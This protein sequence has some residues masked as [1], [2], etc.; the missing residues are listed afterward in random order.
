MQK[1]ISE[2]DLSP[3]KTATVYTWDRFIC[4]S[5]IS[6]SLHMQK[7]FGLFL[8]DGWIMQVRF[9]D[10][11]LNRF[12]QPDTMGTSLTSP[13]TWNR[14]SYVGNNSI[15]AT[16]PSG[17]WRVED[18]GGM[19]NGV[20]CASYPQL[21]SK[22]G[23]VKSRDELAKMRSPQNPIVNNNNK[24]DQSPI[25]NSGLVNLLHLFANMTQDIATLIDLG[26]AAPE[27]YLLIVGTASA[28]PEAIPVVV[29]GL[30][31]AFN[32]SGANLAEMSFSGVSLGFT[33]I[34]DTIG[35]GHLG[36]STLTSFSTFV[37][38]AAMPDPI[39]DLIID[40]YGSGYNH[41]LFSGITGLM[42][43]ASFFR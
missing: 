38:G 13:Q 23:K 16:D 43:S 36:D 7:E 41:G 33:A 22:K 24:F 8:S 4:A 15:N 11:Y 3:Q 14:Y 26:F 27:V 20:D 9:N 31:L 28:G 34:A 10:P 42:N 18:T 37:A 39:G 6:F 35:D 2:A 40:G 19:G 17:H 25:N 1:T 12:L 32:L 5:P 30:D 29:I 21:C